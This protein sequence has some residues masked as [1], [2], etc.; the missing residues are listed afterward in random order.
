MTLSIKANIAILLLFFTGYIH[1]QDSHGDKEIII[2]E[3]RVDDQG[4]V[5]S[6]QTKRYSGQYS[7]EELQEL[8]EQDG[9]PMLRSHDLDGLGYQDLFDQMFGRQKVSGKPMIGVSVNFDQG[10]ALIEGVSP[11]SDA[12]LKDLRKGDIIIAVDHVAISSIQDINDIVGSK[13]AGDAIQIDIIRDGER[14]TK[15]VE[16]TQRGGGKNNFFLDI[17]GQG[18]FGFFGDSFGGTPESMDSILGHLFNF[19]NF[20]QDFN[21]SPESKSPRRT[22][23]KSDDKKASLGLFLDTEGRGVEVT[24]VI[25][26]SPADLAGIQIGDVILRL[27]DNVITSFREISAYMNIKSKGDSLEIT[28]SREGEQMTLTAHL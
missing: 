28:L 23:K 8:I 17:P 15:K 2:I 13:K 3:K 27:D 9:S 11:G 4:N 20:G 18:E 5:I 19:E 6:Q 12:D 26:N 7:E 22:K 1:A 16:L 25:D 10:T 14:I 24:E 21:L